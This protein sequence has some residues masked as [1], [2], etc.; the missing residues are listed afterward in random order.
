MWRG[1]P[2]LGTT[3]LFQTPQRLYDPEIGVFTGRDPLLYADSPSPYAYA[4]HNPV[5]FADPTGLAKSPLGDNDHS[6]KQSTP[7]WT[8]QTEWA[9]PRPDHRLIQPVT[10]VNTGNRPLNFLLNKVLLPWRNLLAFYENIP[11]ATLIGIDEAI[12]H[13][14]FQQAYH[15]AQ[16]MA[17]MGRAMG[18]AVEAGPAMEYAGAWL[19]AM[20][21]NRR[22]NA[23]VTAS[24]I[25]L[26]GGVGGIVGGSSS[27][28]R[29][30]IKASDLGAIGTTTSKAT[31][32]RL[33]TK[34]IQDPKN[35]LHK[36]LDPQTGKL[37]P[38]T[39]RGITE[40]E[41]FENP[42]IIEA[43][44]DASAKQLAGTPDRLMVMSAYENR[45]I[46]AV[47]EHPSKG[48][49]MLESGTILAIGGVPIDAK[50]A[51]DLV[52]KGVV[53]AEHLVNAP[54]VIY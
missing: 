29:G 9:F 22:L 35:P 46:S 14:E 5:D 26:M 28:P 15:A 25:T 33:L 3:T 30:M 36:L 34:L 43:G 2:A 31:F 37:R 19:S 39:A 12:E 1:M 42:E 32:R 38:S 23:A 4:A 41:W 53:D 7:D 6:I 40:L 49:A 21:A 52:A 20:S 10:S 13:S 24:V 44:H 18:I 27:T 48:G 54:I 47:L 45:L 51:S 11:L 8:T 17:P 50:T 16:M